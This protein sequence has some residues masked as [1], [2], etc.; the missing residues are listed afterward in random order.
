MPTIA[1][2]VH[3]SGFE[4]LLAV[5]PQWRSTHFVMHHVSETLSTAMPINPR[6]D[7]VEL[8]TENGQVGAGS[9]DKPMATVMLGVLV[10]K[11]HARRAVTRNL[12]RRQ[13]RAAFTRH[14][15]SLPD[16]SWLVR[17][18]APFARSEFVSAASDALARALRDELELLVARACRN[19][20][21]RPQPTAE[22]A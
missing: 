5:P 16:G 14:A 10:P 1:R 15:P 8:S 21:A 6:A 20:A 4:R 3:R 12:I 7:R 2:L 18:R 17:L 22:A 9:V 19:A 13:V 11:R